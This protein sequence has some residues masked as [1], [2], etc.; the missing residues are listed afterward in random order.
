MEVMEFKD[1]A[2]LAQPELISLEQA[3]LARA[4]EALEATHAAMAQQI[5]RLNAELIT[6]FLQFHKVSAAFET[7]SIKELIFSPSCA[8]AE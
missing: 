5:A 2:T 3:T 7:S 1:H 6:G 8:P 4:G